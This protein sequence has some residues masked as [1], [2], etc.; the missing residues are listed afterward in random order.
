MDTDDLTQTVYR[1]IVLAGE[2]CD[3]LR[4][5]IGVRSGEFSYEDE[6]LRGILAFLDGVALHPEEYLE[7]WGLEE[8]AGHRG[9][10]ARAASLR[11]RRRYRAEP[12]SEADQV[13]VGASSW[14]AWSL[15]QTNAGRPLTLPL[16]HRNPKRKDIHAAEA[17]TPEIPGPCNRVH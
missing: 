8:D 12:I 16:D 10:L 5:D 17:S 7:S 11:V 15:V 13:N 9:R 4:T 2:F 1:T 14:V 6:Y 3:H